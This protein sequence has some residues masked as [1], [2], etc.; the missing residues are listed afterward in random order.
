MVMDRAII[1]TG[2]KQ[3]DLCEHAII[4]TRKLKYHYPIIV[5]S[6]SEV[7]CGFEEMCA[8]H[9]D[10]TFVAFLN[11]PYNENAGDFAIEDFRKF[12]FQL[13]PRILLSLQIGIGVAHT[14]GRTKVA[15][16]HTDCYWDSEKEEQL[17]N[18]FGAL[19]TNLI[20]GDTALFINNVESKRCYHGHKLSLHPEGLF[21]NTTKNIWF[22]Q[23]H[24][25][26]QEDFYLNP[27]SM[28]N[29][30]A[31]WA[32]KCINLQSFAECIAN[33][34]LDGAMKFYDTQVMVMM[35][36]GPHN[37]IGFPHGLVHKSGEQPRKELET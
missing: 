16:W 24:K 2:Y 18:I 25:A 21:I 33:G 31:E 10:V 12:K 34:T 1:I 3:V 20:V 29:V 14:L 32:F 8:R 36:R 7:P 6:T 13:I 5:V 15:H 37:A 19:D 4:E 23:F 27:T 11:A 30:L 35:E 9:K 22:T 26:L 17:D 28:E